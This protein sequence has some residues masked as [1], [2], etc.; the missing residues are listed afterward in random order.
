MRVKEIERRKHEKKA[1]L[2]IKGEMLWEGATKRDGQYVRRKLEE[3]D[4]KIKKYWEKKNKLNGEDIE[5][6]KHYKKTKLR[7]KNIQRQY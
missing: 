5:R 6:R 4:I 3:E 2:N 1:I 7:G